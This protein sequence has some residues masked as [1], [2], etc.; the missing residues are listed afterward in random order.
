LYEELS[1]KEEQV[2]EKPV[3][4]KTVAQE[5]IAQESIIKQVINGELVKESII[6]ADSE[7]K[8][9]K[10]IEKINEYLIFLKTIIL[11]IPNERLNSEDT[12]KKIKKIFETITRTLFKKINDKLLL[13]SSNYNEIQI[14]LIN[15]QIKES[16]LE[17]KIYE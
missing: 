4:E 3:D 11:S 14:N 7:N 12:K 1:N 9:K 17:I 6:K 5:T 16:K 15:S 8:S 13:I 10:M 2:D